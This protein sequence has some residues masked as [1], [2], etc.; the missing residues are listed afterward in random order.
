[1]AV[2][3]YSLAERRVKCLLAG[4]QFS[5]VL[6]AGDAESRLLEDKQLLLFGE[7]GV[8]AGDAGFVGVWFM[9]NAL[10]FDLVAS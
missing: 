7:V 6:M 9:G 2:E 10:V 8:V 1:M 3:A 5:D 4:S